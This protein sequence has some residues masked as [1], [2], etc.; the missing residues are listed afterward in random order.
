MAKAEYLVAEQDNVVFFKLKGTLKYTMSIRFDAYI[1]K[2]IRQ[3]TFTNVVFDITEAEYIDSTNLGLLAKLGEF[4]RTR[5][6]K[7]AI[8]ISTNENITQL[9]ESVGFQDYFT[10]LEDEKNF[11]SDFEEIPQQTGN[12]V[13]S[14]KMIVDAHKHLMKLN[15]ENKSVFQDIVSLLEEEVQERSE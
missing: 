1:E 2:L 10:I 9:L 4:I 3:N 15:E 12:D 13:E 11:S 8:I 5:K 7:N 14:A 6:N